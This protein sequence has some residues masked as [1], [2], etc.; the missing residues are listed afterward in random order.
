MLTITVYS[1][2]TIRHCR[3]TRKFYIEQASDVFTLNTDQHSSCPTVAM[4][5][6]HEQSSSRRQ[7]KDRIES[8]H[9]SSSTVGHIHLDLS[10]QVDSYID[11]V[12]SQNDSFDDHSKD[13]LT[14]NRY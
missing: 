6:D 1:I 5:I 12:S 2:Q 11:D 10:T 9:Y 8:I 3:Q 13:I 7:S 14:S 4:K